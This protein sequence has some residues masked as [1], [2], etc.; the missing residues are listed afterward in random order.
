VTLVANPKGAYLTVDY[1]CGDCGADC[2]LVAPSR[3]RKTYVSAVVAC[4]EC[5]AKWVVSVEML[6]ALHGNQ[7]DTRRPSA[8]EL[9]TVGPV[10]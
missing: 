10:S 3:A 9:A 2:Q 7:V 1:R 6:R 8:K 5:R 4:T